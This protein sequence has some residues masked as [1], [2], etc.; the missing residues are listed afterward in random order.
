M[1]TYQGRDPYTGDVLSIST[2]DGTVTEMARE[3][4]GSVAL[5]WISP[6][7][8]DLQVNGFRG[9]DVNSPACTPEMIL[10]ITDQLARAGTTVWVPTIV[11][12]SEEQIHHALRVIAEARVTDPRAARAIPFAH[13]EGPFISELDGPRGVH[14]QSQIRPIDADEVERWRSSGRWGT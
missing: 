9:R 14:D 8:I 12:A 11:T 3:R 10:E 2:A 5:P 1:S 4:A 13:V 7:L 6:G